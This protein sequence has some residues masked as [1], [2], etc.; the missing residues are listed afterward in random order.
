MRKET[1][2]YHE[3]IFFFLKQKE[4]RKKKKP[5]H[6]IHNSRHMVNSKKSMHIMNP[7]DMRIFYQTTAT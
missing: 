4:K 6:D 3:T 2:D 5:S 1:V 7:M